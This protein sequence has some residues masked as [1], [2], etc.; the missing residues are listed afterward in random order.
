MDAENGDAFISQEEFQRRI[1][2]KRDL[3]NTMC[4]A[5]YLMPYHKG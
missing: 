1:R 4:H 3:Y 2:S 5:G